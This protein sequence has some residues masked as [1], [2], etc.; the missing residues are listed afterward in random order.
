[1]ISLS[2]LNAQAPQSGQFFSQKGQIIN[3]Q[4]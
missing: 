4:T 2:I 3:M 1:M